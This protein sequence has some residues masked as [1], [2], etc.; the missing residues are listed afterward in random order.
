VP[1]AATSLMMLEEAPQG[2][3]LGVEDEQREV[4]TETVESE[5]AER[6]S[7]ERDGESA[8]DATASPTPDT[9]GLE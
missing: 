2:T 7:I 9:T 4:R 1:G 8:V 3:I 5:S 6:A